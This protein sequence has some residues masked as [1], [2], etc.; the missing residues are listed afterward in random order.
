MEL[1]LLVIFSVLL[2]FGLQ[3]IAVLID[4]KNN[5]KN[6]QTNHANSNTTQNYQ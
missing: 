1:I 5:S 4:I 2:T 6:D 3:I